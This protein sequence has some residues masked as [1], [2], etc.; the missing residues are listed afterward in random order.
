MASRKEKERERKKKGRRS[1]LVGFGLVILLFNGLGGFS[2]IAM[3]VIGAVLGIGAYKLL[4]IMGEGLDTTTHNR[5]DKP[6]VEEVVPLSGNEAADSVIAKGQEMLRQIRAA[7]RAIPDLQLTSQ[8]D[9]LEQQCVQIFRTVSEE[10]GKEPQIRKFMSYYLPTT[11]KMLNNY[12]V[13]QERGVSASDLA[14][15][16][17]TLSR[18][19]DLI[20]AACQKELDN[21]HRDTMLDVSTDMDVLEQMLRRDGLLGG[22]GTDAAPMLNTDG[23]GNTATT[24]T[25]QQLQFGVPVLGNTQPDS[26]ADKY[27]FRKYF[28]KN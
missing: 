27:D 10:P 20:I 22:E 4:S 25:A 3:L 16:R 21:L 15:V 24:A 5:Q 12:R 23:K 1:G 8:L 11:L 18:S 6:P 7:N 17:V 2:S 14:E 13:M 28:Q 9:K 19:L 26:D